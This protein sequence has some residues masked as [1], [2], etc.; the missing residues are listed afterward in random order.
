MIM[1]KSDINTENIEN[2]TNEALESVSVQSA[3]SAEI[4]T[5]TAAS[6]TDEIVAGNT[7]PAAKGKETLVESLRILEAL[8]FA[9]DDLLTI[10]KLKSIL[11]G[12]PD[13][14]KI[15]QMADSINQQLQKQR[16]PFEIV[17]VGGGYQFRTLSY[18]YPWV[19]QLFKEKTAKKLSIQS[20]EC[21][22]IIAYKQPITKAEI[23]AVR[24][25]ISDGAMKTLMEKHLVTVSGRSEKAG[26][27]LLYATTK[28]FLSY[29]GLNKIADLPR[30][31]EFETLA[32][33]KLGE[34]SEAELQFIETEK[35]NTEA[36]VQDNIP[37]DSDTANN[38]DNESQPDTQALT[39]VASDAAPEVEAADKESV[40][41]AS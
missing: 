29:F 25:V 33:E 5:E 38:T 20:L 39:D 17:E 16:H 12:Q 28:E 15:R 35:N 34:L 22:A 10:E 11:P 2:Q 18:Y 8:L 30:I 41:D 26:R 36:T 24:G 13:A 23:E 6:D 9:S 4:S 7:S 31:E 3:E 21:L 32:K 27:P 19:Q 37:V 40:P 1:D 14:R